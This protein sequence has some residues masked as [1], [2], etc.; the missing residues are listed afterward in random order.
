MAEGLVVEMEAVG[1]LVEGQLRVELRSWVEV[2][3]RLRLCAAVEEEAGVEPWGSVAV[4]EV[5]G[6]GPSVSAVVG[7]QGDEGVS[8]GF[9]GLEVRLVIGLTDA[10][11]QLGG[12]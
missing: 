12:I 2:R 3:V 11:L 6:M 7:H 8:T 9:G 5:A 10:P 4:E 1:R